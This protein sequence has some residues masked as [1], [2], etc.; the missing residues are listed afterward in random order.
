MG[1]CARPLIQS[2]PV[3]AASYDRGVHDTREA[4]SRD[5]ERWASEAGG[6]PVGL[7]EFRELAARIRRGAR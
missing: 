5:L 3:D 7:E 6:A 4:I 2:A 1:R